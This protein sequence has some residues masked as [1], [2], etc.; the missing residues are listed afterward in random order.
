MLNQDIKNII[1]NY[2]LPNK[3]E[4]IIIKNKILIEL[5]NSIRNIKKCLDSN[6]CYFKFNYNKCNNLN[7]R[8]IKCFD[9]G[10]RYVWTIIYSSSV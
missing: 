9:Y 5:S 10:N 6:I 3:V 2:L 7:N 8:K 1:S 4:I